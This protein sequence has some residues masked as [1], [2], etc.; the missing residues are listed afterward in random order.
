M[1]LAADV[2]YGGLRATLTDVT[3]V[4]KVVNIASDVAPEIDAGGGLAFIAEFEDVQSGDTVDCA[5][6]A[7]D[8]A[9]NEIGTPATHTVVL[10]AVPDDP[11]AKYPQPWY[12]FIQV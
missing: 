6:T 4:P 10:D 7:L 2:S 5:V 11:T 8:S 9:G 12:L 1:A 3:G